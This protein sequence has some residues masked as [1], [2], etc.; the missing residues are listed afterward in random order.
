MKK[1]TITLLTAWLLFVTG[2]RAQSIQEGLNHLYAKRHQSAADVFQKLIAVNPNNIDAIY[3]LGQAY[4]NMDDNAA[5]RQLYEKALAT[6]GSAPLILVGIGHAD[7]LD[8]KNNDARQRFEAALAASRTN[9]GDNP[10]VQT[11]IGRA[12]V[13]SKTGDF[14][15]AIQLLLAATAK[16][17]KN[18]E[19]LLQLGNAY[20]KADPGKGGSDA[21]TY[22]MKALAVNPNFAVASVRLAKLFETQKNWDFVL[23]YLNEAVTKDSKFTDAY[24]E[25]FWYYFLRKDFNEAG[26]QLKKYIDSKLPETDI[27]DEYLNGQLCYVSKDYD[28]AILKATKVL[29]EMGAK[30]KPRVYKLLAYAYFD[31]GDYPN[32][33]KNVNDYFA[34]E[35]PEDIIL[36]DVKLKADILSKTGGSPDEIY[37]TYIQGVALDSVLTSKIDFLKQGA[38]AFK[39]KGDSISRNREGDIRMAIINLKPKIN[40]NDYYDAGFAY[41]KGNNYARADSLFE[42]ITVKYPDEKY[43][44]E[45]RFQIAR[46]NDSTMEKGAAVPFALKYLEIL[47]RDTAKNKREIISTS[48][49][50]A[51]YYANIAKDK[52]KALEYLKK[53]LVFDPTNE[54]IINNINALEKAPAPKP[55]GSTTPK[56][57]ST[58]PPVKK[59]TITKAKTKTKTS[60]SAKNSVAKLS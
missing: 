32:A 38:D 47:E 60:S 42:I 21:Y 54:V 2:L 17:P 28:C 36:G 30:T 33:L 45:R 18:T 52:V 7:L 56:T 13:D 19:T 57:G 44:W 3:W 55:K 22:Y 15:Y 12:I 59:T 24:Y 34:K 4:F 20:R 40:L 43:G 29:S 6:N 48:S 5:A 14:N 50:L 51:S 27:Q 11:A 35:K 46:I 58:K 1:T 10:A 9:K 31:K 26:N 8:N 53:M 25:L 16:D 23:Q 49:Y 39:A 41:Y 37:N